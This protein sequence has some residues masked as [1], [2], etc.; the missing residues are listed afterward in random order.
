MMIVRRGCIY[1][2]RALKLN[3]DSML[4]SISQRNGVNFSTKPPPS[5]PV[6][7]GA[8]AEVAADDLLL[9]HTSAPAAKSQLEPALLQRRVVVYDGVCPLCHT[10]MS[11]ASLSKK[12]IFHS[13]VNTA[14]LK[15]HVLLVC[16]YCVNSDVCK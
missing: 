13:C 9:T 3:F 12:C 14:F 2:L 5:S 8:A 16:I 10:G 4:S 11:S 1:R 15:A 6:F 7:Y